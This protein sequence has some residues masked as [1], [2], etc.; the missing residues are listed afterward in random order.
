MAPTLT[1][2]KTDTV[3]TPTSVTADE[4]LRLSH[5]GRR[6][7]LIRGE[8]KEMS[9]AGPRHGRIAMRLGS[10][11]EQYVRQ[12]NLGVVYAAETGFKLRENPDTVRAADASFVAQNRIPSTGE[13]EGYWAIAPDLVVEVVSP[14]D[15]ALEIQSK[16][17]DW[18]AADCRLVWVIY[19]DTQMVMEYR[20]LTEA[21]MLT[22]EET[23]EGFDVLPGFTCPISQIFI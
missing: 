6:Y 17:S 5:T 22:I 7:E 10:L 16:V 11:I 18:L 15:T 12:H 23:L 19:P 8:L 13:P 20:S 2:I 3:A 1:P 9:P 4:L 14:N 21:R